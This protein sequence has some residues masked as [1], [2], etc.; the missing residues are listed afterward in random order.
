[1][2]SLG[3]VFLNVLADF[4][5]PCGVG[6]RPRP[7]GTPHWSIVFYLFLATFP[8]DVLSAF[9]A[10]CGRVAYAFYAS[11]PERVVLTG[12]INRQ[13]ALGRKALE[14]RRRRYPSRC[15]ASE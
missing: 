1:M 11:G 8:C 12:G 15:A 2:A 7:S 5:A 3:G 14:N 9:L 13:G 10:F 6:L 4:A